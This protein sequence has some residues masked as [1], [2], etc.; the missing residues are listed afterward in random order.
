MP[1]TAG[2]VVY[3]RTIQVRQFEPR[4]VAVEIAFEVGE[5][6]KLQ[7]LIDDASDICKLAVLDLV[8]QSERRER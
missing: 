1:L 8:N 7:D 3:S 5:K 2:K 4:H 6:E